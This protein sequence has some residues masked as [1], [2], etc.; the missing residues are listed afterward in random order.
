MSGKARVELENVNK[1]AGYLRRKVLKRV[2]KSSYANVE[3]VLLS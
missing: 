2:F 3:L 1:K